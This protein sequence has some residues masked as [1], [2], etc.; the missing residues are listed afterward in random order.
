MGIERSKRTEPRSA[1]RPR[2]PRRVSVLGA[3]GSI[4]TSTLDL[5]GAAPDAFEIVALTGNTNVDLLADL[6]LRHRARL[7]VIGESRHYGRLAERLSGAGIEV[8]AGEAALVEAASR[9]A[10]CV[11]AGMVGLAGL[12][13]ALA[14]VDQ[15]RRVGLANKECLVSAGTVFMRRVNEAGAE[16][17]PVDSEHSAVLQGLAGAD[18]DSVERITITASGGP[19]RTW[20]LERLAT[21]TVEDALKHPNWTMGRKITIDSATLFNKG[22]ELIEAAHLF[23]VGHDRIDAVVHPQSIVHALVGYVDGSVVAQLAMPDMRTPIALSLS[24][25]ARMVTPTHRLDLARIGTLTFEP[26]DPVRFPALRL[27]REALERGG[28]APAVLNA[29]NEIAVEAFL[30]GRATFLDIARMVATCLEL[31]D[32][33]GVIQSADSL[34]AVMAADGSAR[35]AARSL[36]RTHRS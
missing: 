8:A 7:A 4:G 14:A 17:I 31:A 5:I 22:L 2:A 32:K 11:I 1:A 18:L 10:D 30:S 29:A 13:P 24:W 27:A 16:L 12:K 6:A 26:T 36:V 15:G 35:E 19:F 34:D 33:R 3:T 21:A 25:P 23:P 20:S 28:T 9:P